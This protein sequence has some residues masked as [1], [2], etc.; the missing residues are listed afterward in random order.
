VSGDRL[1]APAASLKRSFFWSLFG[2]AIYLASQWGMLC[3]L[4]RGGSPEKLGT[5]ALGAAISA[6]VVLFTSLGLRRLIATDAAS[7][8][9]FSDYFGLRLLTGLVALAAIAVVAVG[10]GYPA[11]TVGVILLVGA[12]KTVEAMSDVVY[13][14]LQQRE[15]MRLIAQSLALRGVA[16]LAGLTVGL[17]A[18]DSVLWAVAGMGAG[19]A[20]VLLLHDLPCAAGALADG[21]PEGRSSVLP[22]WRRRDLRDLTRL[23][24]P[25]GAVALTWS[26]MASIPCIVIERCLGGAALGIYTVLAYGFAANT[27]IAAALGESVCPRLA[28][29]YA[30]GRRGSYARLLAQTVGI[31]AA[32][33]AFSAAVAFVAGRPILNFFFG[34]AYGDH[35]HLLR[36]LLLVA[37]LA[38]AQTM[39]D[40]AMSASRDLWIQPALYAVS[41]LLYA[42]LCI[43][44][45]PRR[46][47]DGAVL[48]LASITVLEMLAALAVVGKS[49]AR[50]RVVREVAA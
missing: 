45:I 23:S 21:P 14:L 28:R 50:L 20:L 47:L 26:L 35:V 30:S 7:R 15:R 31:S 17:R 46:G 32:I 37:G 42:G 9:R 44:L 5:F 48:A 2:S 10:G 49:I 12:A 43:A 41:A 40:Y 25:L 19:W 16:S 22:R 27:R 38:N 6:P 33:G 8:F 1:P 13:G 36:G 11:R 39:L 3:V 18:T 34:T 4:A 29:H 24:L